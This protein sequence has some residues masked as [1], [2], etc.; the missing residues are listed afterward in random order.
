[1]HRNVEK[2]WSRKTG[3]FPP[4]LWAI[5]TIGFLTDCAQEPPA[6]PSGGAGLVPTVQ[7]TSIETRAPA[8]FRIVRDVPY[9]GPNQTEKLDL[10]LPTRNP[11]DS[12]TPA[13]IWMHGN[14]HD[15]G[16]AREHNVCE[17]LAGA[18]YVCASINYGTWAD[19]DSAPDAAPHIQQNIA[20]ARTAVR[21]LRAHA[22]E[23]H[24]DPARIAAFGGSAGGFLALM[25][26]FTNG[27]AGSGEMGPDPDV[28][29]AVSVIGDFY[30]DYD[31]AMLQK[32]TAKF[33]P[34]LIAQGKKDPAVDYRQSSILA[35]ALAAKGVPQVYILLDNVGHAFD[36]TSWN[37]KPLPQDLRPVVLAFLNKYLGPPPRPVPAVD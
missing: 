30:G 15:K 34:I 9:L 12:L 24:I 17:T 4:I 19:S 33:P 32:L 23:Y 35:Q 11:P 14:H 16:D 2:W 37:N 20:N 10:Y 6:T 1:M 26:G 25:L 18:G 36:L 28:S 7:P 5:V 27:D 31:P 8:P 13:V 22:G 29:S 3:I 21:F